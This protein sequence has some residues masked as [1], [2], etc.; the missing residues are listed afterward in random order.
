MRLFGSITFAVTGTEMSYISQSHC[1]CF[2]ASSLSLLLVNQNLVVMFGLTKALNTSATG[3]RI[4]IPV[5]V[6]G[7]CV[8]CKFGWLVSP[9]RFISC[10]LILVS[11]DFRFCVFFHEI[12]RTRRWSIH[13]WRLHQVRA[14]P[15]LPNMQGTLGLLRLLLRLLGCLVQVCSEPIQRSLPELSILIDPLRG[16]FQRFGV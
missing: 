15:R 4:S 10:S 12:W 9:T 1:T 16:F 11:S 14:K 3:F 7:T 13:R 5:L 6:T 2:P 8:S